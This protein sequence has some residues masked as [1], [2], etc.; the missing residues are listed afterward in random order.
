M[1]SLLPV[2]PALPA[3]C[4]RLLEHINLNVPEASRG[5]VSAFF[6]ALGAA[7]NP[8]GSVAGRQLHY[9][10]G[11]SQFHLPYVSVPGEPVPPREAQSWRGTIEMVTAEDPARIAERLREVA[12]EEGG[13]PALRRCVVAL[14]DKVGGG[15]VLAL[16]CPWG[17]GFIRFNNDEEENGDIS[18]ISDNISD[19]I[20]ENIRGIPDHIRPD[21]MPDHNRENNREN[22]REDAP[23]RRREHD[24]M[25]MLIHGGGGGALETRVRACEGHDG[26]VGAL[27]AMTRVT[28]LVRPGA[29]ACLHRFFT[30]ILGCA[31]ASISRSM[32]SSGSSTAS[33]TVPFLSKAGAQTLVFEESVHAGPADAYDTEP[34]SQYHLALYLPSAV[35]FSRAFERAERLGVIFVNARFEDGPPEFASSTTLE[36]AMASG[37]FRVKNLIHPETGQL[38]LTLELEVRS[39]THCCFPCAGV[40]PPPPA[41]LPSGGISSSGRQSVSPISAVA[42]GEEGEHESS[43]AYASSGSG[44]GSDQPASCFPSTPPRARRRSP[45]LSD[46]ALTRVAM[47][48]PGSPSLSYQQQQN[49]VSLLMTAGSPQRSQ[50]RSALPM[51]PLHRAHV[52]NPSESDAIPDMTL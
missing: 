5:A 4:L 10:V 12:E 36:E 15:K 42:S 43:S 45:S 27:V 19:N 50:T 52:A 49:M 39:P 17:E 51:S 40:T 11:L 22:S 47:S 30:D 37:Q 31:A 38:G 2:T 34:Q 28:H 46:I 6:L 23:P 44:S 32:S 35:Q 3:T 7:P 26:G 48:P 18:D 21:H 41:A 25:L 1:A 33:C 13:Y 29:A 14:R 8:S 16:R 24:T 20:S 9:N